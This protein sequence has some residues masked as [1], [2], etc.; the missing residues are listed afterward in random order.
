[1]KLL[2]L[3]SLAPLVAATDCWSS[4]YNNTIAYFSKA[5][6]AFKYSVSGPAACAA[7][8]QSIDSCQA[9]VYLP[10]PGQC[11]LHRGA[12]LD[13][14]SNTGFVYGT[15][16]GNSSA[17]P[18]ETTASSSTASSSAVIHPSGTVQGKARRDPLH[19]THGHFH[20]HH[21]GRT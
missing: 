20:N 13:T 19:N 5:P 18:S 16:R 1:M 3:A 8:C 11:D 15:C 12:P 17:L 14:A 9:W 6:I 4:S 2:L 21:G 7:W 10:R